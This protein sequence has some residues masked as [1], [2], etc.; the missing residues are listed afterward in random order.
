MRPTPRAAHHLVVAGLMVTGLFAGAPPA[1]AV[2]SNTPDPTWMTTGAVWSII[3][4]GDYVYVGGQFDKVRETPPGF[5]GESFV[6]NG[7]ARFDAVTGAGDPTW[8]PDVSWGSYVSNSKPIVYALAAAG[9]KIFVGGDFGAIDGLPRTNFAAVDAMTGAVDPATTAS[10]GVLGSKGV[11]ALTA[12]ADRVYLGGSFSAIDGQNRKHLAA[13]GVDGTLDAAWKPKADKKVLS[14]AWD[15]TASALFVGGQFRRAASA[16]GAY[17]TRETVARFDPVTGALLP[18]SIPVGTIEQNQK[19][20]DMAAT[21]TQLN[22]GYGGRNYAAAFDLTDDVGQQL[23]RDQTAGNVQTVAVMGDRLILGGHFSQV[24]QIRRVRIASVFLSDGAVD[25]SWN[26]NVE[27]SFLGPWELLVTGSQ[28]YV[29]GFF[30]LVGGVPQ[31]FFA[32]FTDV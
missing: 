21:C 24:N 15:C 7:L 18:W 22:I 14:L 6:A 29:G 1:S 13:F 20:Y 27:G 19:A 31:Y 9:G 25:P 12:S 28:L 2:M 32:R 17:E 11:R 26:P 8:T 5:P 4:Y 16:G 23:W 30:D 3:R 10:V